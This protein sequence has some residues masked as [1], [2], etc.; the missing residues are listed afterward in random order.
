MALLPYTIELKKDDIGWKFIA[1]SSSPLLF[2]NNVFEGVIRVYDI[3]ESQAL[4]YA[5]ALCDRYINSR[6]SYNV[7][8]N[9]ATKESEQ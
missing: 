8:Y 5:M 4:L 3:R 2:E 9:D 1:K 7:S 6:K